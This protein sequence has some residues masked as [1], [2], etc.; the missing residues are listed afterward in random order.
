MIATRRPVV[1][2]ISRMR[3]TTSVCFEK[4]PWEKFRRA[5]FR[6]ALIRRS[7]ISF[8]S[9][10]GP[11]VATIFV[12]CAGKAVLMRECSAGFQPAVSPTSLSAM[13]WQP[14]D[15]SRLEVRDTAG[16]KPALR[17]SSS[18]DRARKKRLARTKGNQVRDRHPGNFS[19]CFLGKKSL[20]RSDQYIWESKEPGQFI[21]L[22][23]FP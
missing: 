13:R 15:G 3:W 7:S 14:R 18:Q 21:I 20:M 2:A 22:Q 23:D 5:T 19:K 11:M 17:N 4:S 9:E 12:L 6:P 8:D 1:F 16:W 10:A